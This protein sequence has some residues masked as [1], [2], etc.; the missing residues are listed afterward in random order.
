EAGSRWRANAAVGALDADLDASARATLAEQW[1]ADAASEHASIAAFARL[2]L[3]LMALG[4]G[5]ELLAACHRAAADEVR[6]AEL[7]FTV[8]RAYAGR[9]LDPGP[10]AVPELP[11]PDVVRMACESFVDGCIGE[12]AA[13]A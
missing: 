12:G 9:E 11:A 8:A 6:H 5:P 10:L 3:E 4:A 13:A 7:C 1:L 2:S